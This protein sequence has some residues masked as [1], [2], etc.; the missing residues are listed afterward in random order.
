MENIKLACSEVYCLLEILGDAY[1][2]KL[3]SKFL[4]FVNENRDTDFSIEV[5]E[6]DFEN[7]KI[8][9]DGLVLISFLNL[10]YWVDD[11]NEKQ[12]LMEIYKKN[13]EIKQE[14]L[15]AYKQN[16][17]LS[18]SNKKENQEITNKKIEEV[19]SENI[20]NTDESKVEENSLILV[21]KISFLDKIK[22]IIRKIFNKEKE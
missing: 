13:D 20:Q 6:N 14:K 12:R 15:N 9:K 22:N 11:E 3:P 21:K 18:S 19:Y 2:N 8:S 1:K 10:K 5:N 17:W 4:K 16:D 7:L